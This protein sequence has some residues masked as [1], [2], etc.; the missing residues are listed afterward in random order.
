[1]CQRPELQ[2]MAVIILL[3]SLFPLQRYI[4]KQV[5]PLFNHFEIVTGNWNTIPESPMDQ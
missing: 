5:K 4:Q 3:L 2:A 1:M